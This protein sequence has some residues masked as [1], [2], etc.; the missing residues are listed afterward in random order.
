MTEQTAMVFREIVS[1][2][3]DLSEEEIVQVLN[4]VRAIKSGTF[5]EIKRYRPRVLNE[6]QLAK[7]YDESGDEDKQLAEHGMSDF[8]DSLKTEDSDAK[9]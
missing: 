6:S 5:Y 1:E 7:L 9:G 2:L 4:F 8:A 3:E